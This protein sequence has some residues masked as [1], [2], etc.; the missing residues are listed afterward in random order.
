MAQIYDV[1]PGCRMVSE[2]HTAF[3]VRNAEGP[4]IPPDL[5]EGDRQQLASIGKELGDLA[6]RLKAQAAEANALGRHGLGLLLVRLQLHIEENGE[7]AEA[8][9]ERDIV[10][11]LDAL[12]DI[13]YVVDGTY[14]TTGLARVKAAADYE[15]HSSNMT[16]LGADG[17][18]IIHASGRVVKGPNYRP[19]DLR[20]VLTAHYAP[21]E[22]DPTILPARAEAAGPPSDP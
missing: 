18:P 4:Y 13:S 20:G 10:A 8:F 22:M 14:L 12:T 19:P 6:K 15:V 17:R 16:K 7:L 1:D 2:F 11:V 5:S 3:G 21:E 9:A